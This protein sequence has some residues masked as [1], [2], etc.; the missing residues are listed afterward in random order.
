M[1][2]V[3]LPFLLL[4]CISP[5]TTFGSDSLLTQWKHQQLDKNRHELARTIIKKF[6][7]QNATVKTEVIN[8]INGDIE[9]QIN[10][11]AWNLYLEAGL[12]SG[13]SNYDLSIILLDSCI[14]ESRT[15]YLTILSLCEK[16]KIHTII[17]EM[18]FAYTA[19]MSSLSGAKSYHYP[20]LILKNYV[21]LAEFKRKMDS[22]DEGMAYLDSAVAIIQK[23]DFKNE[24]CIEVLDRRAALFSLKSIKDSIPYY[25]KQ[26]LQLSIELG[27]HHAEAVSCNELGYY[28]AEIGQPD[29]AI[30]YYDRAIEIWTES[31]AVVYLTSVFVNK[32]EL[33]FR[34]EKYQEAEQLLKHAENLADQHEW[35]AMKHPIYAILTRLYYHQNKM[36]LRWYYNSLH[37]Q[38][39]LFAEQKANTKKIE[40]IKYK[41]EQYRKNK[42]LQEKD[43]KLEIQKQNLST[44]T[45][46]RNYTVAFSI[47]LI[48]LLFITFYSL[49]RTKKSQK[50]LETSNQELAIANKTKDVLLAEIHHRVKNNFQ[51]ISSLLRIQARSIQ[52]EKASNELIEA[53]GR[54]HALSQVHQRLYQGDSFDRIQLNELIQDIVIP[55]LS[56]FDED[57]G[58]A[59]DLT[60]PDIDIHIE[61]AVPL[62]SVVHELLTNSFKYAWPNNEKDKKIRLNFRSENNQLVFEYEDN[63]V[64]LPKDYSLE[65]PTSMGSTIIQISVE[66]QLDGKCHFE[67]TKGAKYSFIF[68]LRYD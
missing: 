19:F 23:Y 18:D 45:Q 58:D 11:N 8:A 5:L 47:I 64:G 44:S 29:S 34:S 3:L 54:V 49:S 17:S 52:D 9:E 62:G 67:I 38:S 37:F 66:R 1:I 24:L 50:E 14:K 42:Q 48:I 41:T 43:L 16:G 20:Q 60:T 39:V 63:G 21:H 32:A 28:F 30:P 59:I 15:P 68:D 31:K 12:V 56:T 57:L 33:L 55:I 35:S 27:D 6:K 53:E 46:Q 13:S 26:A 7:F 61:Q 36:E 40:R 25:S 4:W 51:M 2:R 10:L 65:N 22:A